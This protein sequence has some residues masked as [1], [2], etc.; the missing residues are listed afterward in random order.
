MPSVWTIVLNFNQQELTAECISALRESKYPK[1]TVV[2]VDNGSIDGSVDFLRSSFPGVNVIANTENLGFAAGNN[3]GIQYALDHGADLIWLLNN[4][5]EIDPDCITELVNASVEH[6]EYA[7]FAPKVYY[8]EP[9]NMIWYAGGEID[10]KS[11]LGVKHWGIGK[12]DSEDF[13][14]ERPISFVTGCAFLIRSTVAEKIGGLDESMFI[15]NEDV[16]WSIRAQKA[17]YHA[18]Y[19][20]KALLWHKVSQVYGTQKGQ[21]VKTYLFAR[22][23]FVIQRRYASIFDNILLIPKY[24]LS[25]V[26]RRS[27]RAVWAGDYSQIIA[28]AKG[29]LDGIRE[30]PRRYP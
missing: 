16:D 17:G 20:P 10:L 28:L 7:I 3:I 30:A 27:Y 25:S 26:A 9:S 21:Y 29:I 2:I 6:P 15:Y 14:H 5:T 23:R 13:D 19:V 8:F 22:N 12:S 4:D 18:Y 1:T 11:P 24:L